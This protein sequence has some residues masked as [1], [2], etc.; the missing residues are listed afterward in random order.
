MLKETGQKPIEP[1]TSSNEKQKFNM[2]EDPR[3]RADYAKTT[4]ISNKS[5]LET[6][7]KSESNN[8]SKVENDDSR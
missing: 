4:S 3:I 5:S 7:L 2:F 8:N 1:E 6:R